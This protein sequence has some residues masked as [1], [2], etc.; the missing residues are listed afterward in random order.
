MFTGADRNTY[1]CSGFAGFLYTEGG[2]YDLAG[3]SRATLSSRV[4][5][6]LIV[7]LVAAPHGDARRVRL[8]TI[9]V[10]DRPAGVPLIQKPGCKPRALGGNYYARES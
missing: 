5:S 4:V 6:P 7:V 1:K 9:H 2:R 3:N 8:S 10:L